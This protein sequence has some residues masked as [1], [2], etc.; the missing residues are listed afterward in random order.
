MNEALL[1]YALS[2][3]GYAGALSLGKKVFARFAFL[4]LAAGCAMN[5]LMIRD[6]WV[7]LGHAPLVSLYDIM[8]VL[9]SGITLLSAVIEY[10]RKIAAAG[11]FA[12]VTALLLLGYAST[13]DAGIR[14]L[15]PA[16]RSNILV[17]H[18]GA[19][20]IGYAACALAFAASAAY[21]LAC[22]NPDLGFRAAVFARLARGC[23]LFAFPFLTAGISLGMVWANSAWGRYWGWDPKESWSLITWL[24][25]GYCV[26]MLLLREGGGRRTA[27]LSIA[28]FSA[29]LFT[30]LGV[31]TFL[32]GLHSYR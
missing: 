11:L 8:L 28:G 10:R 19:Y 7:S 30:L 1:S 31:N 22:R 32:S 16:L 5:I 29:I 26:H 27:W 13:L 24:I 4:A 23:I 18:V 12:G 15:V 6:R 2:A 3:A 9:A 25:Y 17:F 14:P 20:L 21:L